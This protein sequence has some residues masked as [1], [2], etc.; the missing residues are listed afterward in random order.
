MNPGSCPSV[1]WSNPGLV[2]SCL[3]IDSWGPARSDF[4]DAKLKPVVFFPLIYLA[5][6]LGSFFFHH[7]PTPRDLPKDCRTFGH[8]PTCWRQI[9]RFKPDILQETITYPTSGK[10]KIIFKHALGGYLLVCR[11]EFIIHFFHRERHQIHNSR[12]K[13]RPQNPFRSILTFLSRLSF[14]GGGKIILWKATPKCEDS[15]EA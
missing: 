13:Q 7:Q 9:A 11:R 6:N 15:E 10:R 5:L 2:D 14:G 12:P 4:F 3:E 1:W 8:F